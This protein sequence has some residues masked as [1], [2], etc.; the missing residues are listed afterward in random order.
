MAFTSQKILKP[1]NHRYVYQIHVARRVVQ[2]DFKELLDLSERAEK[3]QWSPWD[4]M[5]CFSATFRCINL[6]MIS[7]DNL[8][9]RLV[10]YEYDIPLRTLFFNVFSYIPTSIRLDVIFEFINAWLL[11]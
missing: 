7:L 3:Y 4:P 11:T 6:I 2:K 10:I 5:V 8:G 9:G 1:P